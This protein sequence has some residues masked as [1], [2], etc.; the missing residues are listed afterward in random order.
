MKLIF[1]DIDGVLNGA[2]LYEGTHTNRIRWE[3]VQQV[4]RIV[5]AT[6][7][8]VV[9]SSAWR[10]LIHSRQM[11][12]AGF[13]AML[14]SHGAMG[15]KMQGLTAPDEH[16]PKCGYKHRRRRGKSQ[17]G[18]NGGVCCKCDSPITRGLQIRRWLDDYSVNER[19]VVI[20]DDDDGIS[21]L[22]LPFVQTDAMCGLTA[23]DADLA[24]GLL[25]AKP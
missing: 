5:A 23:N 22:K 24:I 21:E 11:K 20:D 1:L 14:H 19:Y 16:C 9:L 7:A 2:N 15:W 10:Y 4:N 25:N 8:Q 3:C 18:M 13:W 12:L 17:L 6:E